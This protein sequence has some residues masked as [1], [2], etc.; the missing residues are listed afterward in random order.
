[1]TINS[2]GSGQ[3]DSYTFTDCQLDTLYVYHT[4]ATWFA[5]TY[6]DHLDF[7]ITLD[8]CNPVGYFDDSRGL[9]LVVTG[10]YG[11][12]SALSTTRL[13]GTAIPIL[14][15]APTCRDG[16]GDAGFFGDVF[17]ALDVSGITLGFD[18]HAGNNTLA[19]RLG[20]R[21]AAPI[22]LSA[23]N[24]GYYQQDYTFNTD[25]TAMTDAQIIN[26]VNTAW[27]GFVLSTVN[28]SLH[29]Y[30]RILGSES[31]LFNSGAGIAKW[32]AVA[33]AAGGWQIRPM[34]TGDPATA[35]AGIALERIPGG[36]TGR[37]LR[38][39]VM[40]K[41]QLAGLSAATI[42]AGTVLYHSDTTAGQFATT[43]PRVALS[44]RAADWAYFKASAG[45]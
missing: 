6:A 29:R 4:D 35:F 30:P 17:G 41:T 37:I 7:R 42:A 20:N 28:P 16:T 45:Q 34:A 44:G 15:G 43:G 26:L 24:E 21:T 31:A 40:H 12:A 3:S 23:Y 18:A 9:A 10:G 19:K 38:E 32:S 22:T 1:M 36:K 27:V 8:R 39:G 13:L 11:S 14:F 25:Y 33:Y 5:D 2:L